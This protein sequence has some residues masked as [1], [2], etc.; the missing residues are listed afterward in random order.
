MK[1]LLIIGILGINDILGTLGIL[2]IVGFSVLSTLC[3]ILN[4]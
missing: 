2:D 4:F 3:I 1:S